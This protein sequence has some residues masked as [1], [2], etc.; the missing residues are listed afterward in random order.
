MAELKYIKL[1]ESFDKNTILS[2]FDKN[3]Q[4]IKKLINGNGAYKVA[5]K[6]IELFNEIGS[7]L[8]KNNLL[9]DEH[10]K[11]LKE[12]LSMSNKLN[13]IKAVDSEFINLTKKLGSESE[14]LKNNL[15]GIK[16][17]VKVGDNSSVGSDKSKEM[18]KK[19]PNNTKE[20]A[21]EIS[22]EL[23]RLCGKY[24]ENKQLQD[25]QNSWFEGDNK[26]SDYDFWDDK[27]REIFKK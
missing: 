10:D 20:D 22:S 18:S 26:E 19:Y 12:L 16:S 5:G 2:I 13:S 27:M 4:E 1:F 25:L 9:T 21:K 23:D 11:K 15:S 17:D 3:Q 7:Y 8:K 24:P 6:Y 14:Q